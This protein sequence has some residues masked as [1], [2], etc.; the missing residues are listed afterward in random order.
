MDSALADVS[1]GASIVADGNR[2]TIIATG[3]EVGLA[4]NARELLAQEGIEVRVVSMPC[5]ELFREL[6]EDARNELVPCD[7]PILAVEAAAP[8]TWY[9][10]AD[11]VIGLTRFGASAPGPQVYSELGFTPK[12][13][14]DCARNLV[15]IMEGDG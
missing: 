9:E 2:A 4:M 5:V 6:P 1:R 14:A 15:G 11:D 7:R 10:F 13:V 8:H 12:H 3:S